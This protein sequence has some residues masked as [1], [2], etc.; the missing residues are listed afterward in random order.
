MP[1]NTLKS[2][3]KHIGKIN[4]VNDMK[5]KDLNLTESDDINLLHKLAKAGGESLKK[6]DIY[7]A[8][9]KGNVIHW[10]G[11]DREEGTHLTGKFHIDDDGKAGGFGGAPDSTHKTKADAIKAVSD[12]V[13]KK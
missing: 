5:I 3:P 9:K 1:Q 2:I 6:G 4:K 8:V 7:H 13:S 11:P 10:A 12:R